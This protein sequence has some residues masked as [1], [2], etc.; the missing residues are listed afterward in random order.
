M[1]YNLVSLRSI[2]KPPCEHGPVAGSAMNRIWH[3]RAAHQGFCD[4]DLGSEKEEYC[5]RTISFLLMVIMSNKQNTSPERH[6]P[7]GIMAL[8]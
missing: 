8:R 2:T 6:Q 5:T 4:K 1:T 7:V 3:S